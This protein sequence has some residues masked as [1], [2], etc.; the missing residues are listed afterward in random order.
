MLDSNAVC[1]IAFV[2]LAFRTQATLHKY[3]IYSLIEFW[4][5]VCAICHSLELIKRLVSGECVV[6][7]IKGRP[8]P[9]YYF[10]HCGRQCG[11]SDHFNLLP[12]WTRGTWPWPPVTP[13][14][15]P[16]VNICWASVTTEKGYNQHS[17]QSLHTID[18]CFPTGGLPPK[19]GLGQ[20]WHGC[21]WFCAYKKNI[22][23]DV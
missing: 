11:F 16:V 2:T 9:H 12:S 23:P 14:R 21:G 10:S 13:W 3:S 7:V 8:C 19:C 5:W 22:V 20:F 4:L 1:L 6:T 17:K 15:I 18:L